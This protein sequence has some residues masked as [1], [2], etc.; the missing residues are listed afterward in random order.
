[1]RICL[2]VLLA[3][4]LQAISCTELSPVEQKAEAARAASLPAGL[5]PSG[6]LA[7]VNDSCWAVISVWPK[8]KCVKRT[9]TWYGVYW[10]EED[11]LRAGNE[12]K[13]STAPPSFI[14]DLGIEHTTQAP[15]SQIPASARPNVTRPSE[16]QP[17][18]IFRPNLISL[19]GMP[20][21]AELPASI[22]LPAS[23]REKAKEARKLRL[24]STVIPP[25]DAD[26]KACWVLLTS[27]PTRTW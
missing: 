5:V 13:P 23:V 22:E 4:L 8:R 1:M 27:Y 24:P 19:P 16:A 15:S 17:I 9:N 2:V 26:T 12:G 10:T 14:E 25:S 20:T 3:Y 7:S 11:C 6:Q 18:F 21:W